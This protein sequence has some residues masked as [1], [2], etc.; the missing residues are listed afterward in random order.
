M[1]GADP[2]AGW[3]DI[4]E[5]RHGLERLHPESYGW[6][7]VCCSRNPA[8]AEDVLQTVYLKILEGKAKYGGH[9]SL[10]TWLFA[11]IRRTAQDEARRAALRRLI[12]GRYADRA[13]SAA[14]DHAIDQADDRGALRSALAKVSVRQRQALQLVFYHDLSIEQAAGVM[15]VSV[16][17]ARVHYDRGKKRLRELLADEEESQWSPVLTNAE[18]R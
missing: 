5:V 4:E 17:T 12:H 14:V 6:A 3:A 1:G 7:L 9:A 2:Q 13:G 10:R 8:L 11:V 16:G 15:G 18:S